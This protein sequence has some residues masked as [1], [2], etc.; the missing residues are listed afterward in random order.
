MNKNNNEIN[1]IKKH[2]HTNKCKI[3]ITSS[4]SEKANKWL[5]NE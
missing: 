2:T 1:V 3:N 5:M 4:R